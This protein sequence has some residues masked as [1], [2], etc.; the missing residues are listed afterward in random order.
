MQYD[1][2][3]EI[4]HRMNTLEISVKNLRKSAEDY[5]NAEREYKI[6]LRAEVLRLRDEGMPV[7][8][9]DKVIYGIPSVADK[10]FARDVAQA[11]YEAN[12]ESINTQKLQIRILD[13]QVQ[14]EW[15]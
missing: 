7:G 8:L 6:H 12:Q 9:I 15:K 5:A 14:R 4:Q 10:R 3:S 13:N 11:V 2:I 1:L